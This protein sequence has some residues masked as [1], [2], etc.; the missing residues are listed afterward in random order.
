[1]NLSP[2]I[3]KLIQDR[4]DSGKYASVDDVVA[5]ALA[6]LISRM[7]MVILMLASWIAC[8]R[9]GRKVDHPSMAS[10]CFPN[11]ERFVTG[12]ASRVD[13]KTA[14]SAPGSP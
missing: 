14:H 13:E 3:E 1:M 12:T 2:K 8:W 5:A 6:N 7:N 11:C 10:K 9:T 4:V